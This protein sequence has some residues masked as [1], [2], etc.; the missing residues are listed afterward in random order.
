MTDPASV[1]R[2]ELD[3]LIQTQVTIFNQARL[4]IDAELADFRACSEKI[5]LISLIRPGTS[6]DT[7]RSHSR[8]TDPAR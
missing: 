3:V 1:L 5:L 2:R 7:I 4:V 6:A 8:S